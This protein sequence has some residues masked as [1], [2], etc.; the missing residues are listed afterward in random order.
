MN[1]SKKY[2]IFFLLSLITRSLK[3]QIFLSCSDYKKFYS[4][5]AIAC[6]TMRVGLNV[7]TF[8]KLNWLILI[9]PQE[10]QSQYIAQGNAN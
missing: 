1:T 9:F 2:N 4:L 6:P 8:D 5:C 7:F 10:I 3:K